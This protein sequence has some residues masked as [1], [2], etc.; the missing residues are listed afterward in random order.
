MF[1]LT[2]SRLRAV[3]LY[4]DIDLKDHQQEFS[5]PFEPLP[6]VEPTTHMPL[7]M[8]EV[9]IAFYVE[10]LVLTYDALHHIPTG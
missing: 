4:H 7:E 2:V 3:S 6:T 5:A 1:L 10:K 8:N 9:F